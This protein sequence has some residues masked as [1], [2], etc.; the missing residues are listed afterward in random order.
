MGETVNFEDLL[1]TELEGI[2]GGWGSCDDSLRDAEST[3]R[4]ARLGQSA[5]WN[6][7]AASRGRAGLRHVA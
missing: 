6:P 2:S 1:D 4:H 7:G 3:Q 5:A